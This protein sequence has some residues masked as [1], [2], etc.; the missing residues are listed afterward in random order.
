MN[1]IIKFLIIA[2]P[3]TAV[4]LISS[5]ITRPAVETWYKEIN[6]PS[7]TPPDFVFP[8]VWTILFILMA[9]AAFIVFKSNAPEAQVRPAIISYFVQLIFNFLWSYLFFGK[10]MFGYAFIEI[11]ILWFLILLTIL[12]F[13][14]VSKL[15]AWLLVPYIS[16]VSFASIL[17]YAF[18][19]MNM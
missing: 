6:R 11:I 10:G 19:K 4:I 8:I 17:T 2:I 1:K 15:A 5:S 13:S 3:T 7:F 9:V 16:W 12:Y 14:K 18:Y